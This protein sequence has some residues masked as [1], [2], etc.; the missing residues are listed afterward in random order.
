MAAEPIFAA[1]PKCA[2]GQVT[3][4]NTARDGTGTIV[5]LL[6]AGSAGAKIE[7]VQIMGVGTVTGGMVRL[8]ISTDG[9]TTKRLWKERPVTATTPSATV[10]G[11]LDDF[12]VPDGL[13]P[14]GALIY[15]STHNAETFNVFAFYG[16]F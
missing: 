13:L 12:K 14:N 8:F 16:D 2:I 11:W 1:T 7:R 5:T 3:A 6:T 4:A 15:A 9:G 10:P